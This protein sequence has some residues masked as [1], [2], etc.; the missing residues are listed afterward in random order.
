MRKVRVGVGVGGRRAV[1]VSV[2]LLGLVAGLAVSPV[3]P[4]GHGADH[5]C[6]AGAAASACFYW[7]SPMLR[8]LEWGPVGLIAGFV[9]ALVTWLVVDAPK[10]PL[11]R[12][13]VVRT[14]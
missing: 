4:S 7:A 6:P 8:A 3:A 12:R 13:I 2:M 10:F 9:A 14:R 1:L 11:Q 5:S